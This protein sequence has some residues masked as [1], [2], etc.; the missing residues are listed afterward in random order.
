MY[1]GGLSK[2]SVPV[3]YLEW[4]RL[5]STILCKN[6]IRRSRLITAMPRPI[7]VDIIEARSD[8]YRNVHG[9]ISRER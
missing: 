5:T 8:P 2:C 9:F 3:Y 6:T 7:Y 4:E 1:I